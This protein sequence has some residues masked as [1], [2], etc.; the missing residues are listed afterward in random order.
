M[1]KILKVLFGLVAGILIAGV[2]LYFIGS[3]KVDV[4]VSKVINKPVN[5]VYPSVTNFKEWKKWSSWYAMDTTMKTT[6]EGTPG[7]LKHKYCWESENPDV[8]YGCQTLIEANENQNLKMKLVFTKPFESEMIPEFKFESVDGGTKVTWSVQ[9]EMAVPDRIYDAL[10]D[11][12]G[13]I[14]DNFEKSLNKLSEL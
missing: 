2:V 9:S 7:E 11:I 10:G 4:T 6:Y 5:E 13:G 1:N 12:N 3:D 8:G 14:R